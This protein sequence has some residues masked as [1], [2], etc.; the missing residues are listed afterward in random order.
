[1]RERPEQPNTRDG[2]DA[3]RTDKTAARARWVAHDSAIRLPGHISIWKVLEMHDAGREY[4]VAFDHHDDL[5]VF[6]D[7][8]NPRSVE[9]YQ[10]KTKT[11]GGWTMVNLRASQG[12][13]PRP[14]S[15]IG[16]MHHNMN[17]FGD[18]VARLG[19]ISNLGY[20][21]K[22]KSGKVSNDDDVAISSAQLHDGEID[23][24]R[25]TAANDCEAPCPL[26]GSDRF[27]FETSPMGLAQQEVLVRGRLATT[28]RSEAQEL[29][30]PRRLRFMGR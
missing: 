27:H 26:D 16:K 9:T 3:N 21:L 14:G 8:Q 18:E 5:L 11:R 22:L 20:S 17:V 6:D 30:R 28:L 29:S 25:Q 24:I 15:Y 4:R 12:I 10:I 13:G 1:M 2:P 7:A 23:A 19:F